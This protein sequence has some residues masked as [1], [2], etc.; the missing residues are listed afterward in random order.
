MVWRAQRSTAK[1]CKASPRAATA[2][3]R[4]QVCQAIRSNRTPCL[5]ARPRPRRS[6]RTAR[7]QAR[8]AAAVAR[9]ERSE[10][11]FRR[12]PQSRSIRPERRD[13]RRATM[14]EELRAR[15][16]A[17]RKAVMAAAPSALFFA[18]ARRRRRRKETALA[19]QDARKARS[20]FA[21][22]SLCRT[23]SIALTFRSRTAA[24]SQ[25]PIQRRVHRAC[26]QRSKA[27][28]ERR[29]RDSRAAALRQSSIQRR[30]LTASRSVTHSSTTSSTAARLALRT[31]Q[32]PLH[33]RIAR[34]SRTVALNCVQTFRTTRRAVPLPAHRRQAISTFRAKR[35]C[36][37]L[38][39]AAN[40][41][42]S[43]DA[44][45]TSGAEDAKRK[46]SIEISASA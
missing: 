2:S 1:R 43:G 31:C 37:S 3:T 5:S 27:S 46:E 42:A 38:R 14:A 34:P 23:A 12:A 13:R 33:D 21:S 8:S 45:A 9:R 35:T 4:R 32:W 26:S 36:Q 7:R 29:S 40:S 39:T 20:A 24:T 15:T 41:S 30:R 25:P 10:E 11:A 44:P 19:R 17:R 28:S 18:S 16:R 22:V 6:A